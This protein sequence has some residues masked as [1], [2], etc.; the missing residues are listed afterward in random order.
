MSVNELST[1]RERA[2]FSD[3][4]SEHASR[5]PA[6]AERWSAGRALKWG[7]IGLGI[8]PLFL[9][10]TFLTLMAIVPEATSYMG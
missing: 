6:G 3:G 7:A 1:W 9:V 4:E 2:L 10:G 8:V 5:A